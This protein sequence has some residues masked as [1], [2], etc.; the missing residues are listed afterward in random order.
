MAKSSLKDHWERFNHRSRDVRNGTLTDHPRSTIKRC[1]QAACQLPYPVEQRDVVEQV[2]VSK[3]YNTEK[4][5]ELWTPTL[6]KPGKK[7]SNVFI[8]DR[9]SLLPIYLW[10]KIVDFLSC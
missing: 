1:E 8:D 4:F 5:A 7:K 6:R 10:F 9:S 2:W 3:C